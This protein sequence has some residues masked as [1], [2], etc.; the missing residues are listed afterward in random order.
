MNSHV[1]GNSRGGYD[2]RHRIE[3]IHRKRATE[4][5]GSDCFPVYS[6]RLR[7]MLLPKKFKYDVKQDPVQWLWF[8]A[9]SIENTGG[10]TNMKCL[11]FPFFLDQ[12]PLTWLESLDK[13]LIDE[14]DQLKAQFTSNFSSAM[15]RPGTHMDLAM[16][17]QEQGETLCEYMRR[18]STSVRPQSTSPTRRLLTSSKTD[19]TTVVPSKTSVAA[20]RV[21][22]P[23]SRT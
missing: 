6:A 2:A 11:Y 18:F 13:N 9:L 22:S 3:E 12:A 15:G 14:W 16:V 1:T 20:A 8:H 23:S 21:L 4:A 5:S 7:D 17:N 10:N 19:S